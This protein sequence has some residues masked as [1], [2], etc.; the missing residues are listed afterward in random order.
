VDSRLSMVRSYTPSDGSG[1]RLVAAGGGA[2]ASLEVWDTGTGVYLGALPCPQ[3]AGNISPT[4][5]PR[6]AA[7]GS[8]LPCYKANCASGMATTRSSST[9]YTPTPRDRPCPAW[10]CTRSPRAAAP[11][12][13]RGES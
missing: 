7:P 12:S 2:Q 11:G 1:P 6:T 5:G 3:G 10:R 13:S 8:S 9:P 4:R